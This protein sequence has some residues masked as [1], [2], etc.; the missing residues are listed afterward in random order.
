MIVGISTRSISRDDDPST[1]PRGVETMWSK[2]VEGFVLCPHIR[3]RHAKREGAFQL[4]KKICVAMVV[5]GRVAEACLTGHHNKTAEL[6]G[7]RR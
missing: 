2:Q 3:Q 5:V 6:S 1:M 4:R 7:K